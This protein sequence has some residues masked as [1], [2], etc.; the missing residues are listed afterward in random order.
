M[1]GNEPLQFY[2]YIQR[3]SDGAWIGDVCFHYTPQKNWWDMG[4]VIYALYRNTGYAIPALKIMIEHA[5]G[6]CKISRLHNDFELARNK[7]P[8]GKPISLS[9]L[10]S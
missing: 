4:I 9:A 3:K 8:L 6:A 5:F 1:V 7:S 2:A 10:K